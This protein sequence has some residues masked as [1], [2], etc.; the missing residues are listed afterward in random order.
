MIGYAPPS[1]RPWHRA[2]LPLFLLLVVALPFLPSGA[3][4]Q[5][6]LSFVARRSVTDG[7][8]ALFALELW[9]SEDLSALPAGTAPHFRF[10][11]LDPD[12]GT[13]ASGA[14][15]SVWTFRCQERSGSC[16]G[17]VQNETLLQTILLDAD[18]GAEDGGYP[19]SPEKGRLFDEAGLWHIS[20]GL[21]GTPLEER[22]VWQVTVETTPIS[23]PVSF[24]EDV[25]A[26][27]GLTF[28]ALGRVLA[29]VLWVTAGVLV[30][31]FTKRLLLRTI[32]SPRRLDLTVVR[33]V[34]RII[35]LTVLVIAIAL[36]LWN[37][38][39]VNFWAGLTTLGL[40]SVALGFG[41][42]NTVAN[43]MG[44]I[45]LALDKPFTIGDRIKVGDSWGDVQEI[46]LRSTRI[47]TVKR[48]VVIVPNKLLDEQEI[49]NFTISHPELRLD[50]DVG[51]SYTSDRRLAEALMI[52]VAQEH[53]SILSYPKP[54]VL[55]QEFADSGIK[56]QL[57]CW[58]E[59]AKEARIV[60]SDLR[61]GIKDRFDARGVEIPFPY[62]TLVYHKDL[63]A[64]KRAT[65]EELDA[66]VSV[67]EEV[68]RLVYATA[69]AE[70]GEKVAEAV[71]KLAR[72]LDM[73]LVVAHILDRWT[74]TGAQRAERLLDVFRDAGTHEG[75]AVMTELRE[76]PVVST[77]KHVLVTHKAD[78]L[79]IGATRHPILPTTRNVAD[80]TKEIRESINVP[81]MIIPR[82]LQIGERTIEHYRKLMETRHRERR[83]ERRKLVT[84]TDENEEG[85]EE[86]EDAS[87]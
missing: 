32:F 85:E 15:L 8:G 23:A 63:P 62:R 45:S 75:V 19:W 43:I 49:W 37:V 50:I 46:G 33:L 87:V 24:F 70:P 3:E 80:L 53:P 86:K 27:F 16:D 48:E 5:D 54:K 29:F 68:P 21:E 83:R 22:A 82:N 71:A 38:W 35:T 72:E 61:K 76:G 17:K 51:V 25:R 66:I 30:A 77:L 73:N 20:V 52:E 39:D 64:P 28:G 41:M 65:Q 34:G 6:D 11:L 1:K 79:A 14:P 10:I 2:L 47:L 57:R 36:G 78:I 31:I 13:R 81:V 74:P 18:D 40:L 69:G 12:N 9:A 59:A 7:D 55:L 26:L 84:E 44:G 56:M 67:D 4:A 58:L 60:A 42:Q